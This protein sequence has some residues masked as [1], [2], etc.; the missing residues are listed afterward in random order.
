VEDV[1]RFVAATVHDYRDTAT[2][3]A[4]FPAWHDTATWWESGSL[5]PV[6][7]P[8]GADRVVQ[9]VRGSPDYQEIQTGPTEG[10]YLAVPK[11]DWTYA[12]T[13]YPGWKTYSSYGRSI[14]H[15]CYAARRQGGR[16]CLVLG[17]NYR[18]SGTTVAHDHCTDCGAE[19]PFYEETQS[20]FFAKKRPAKWER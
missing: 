6:T 2:P 11:N 7:I 12:T 8:E 19:L 3:Q 15:I 9:Y 20:Q 16:E 13:I 10:T 18:P 17:P 1:V 5:R 14:C 4:L